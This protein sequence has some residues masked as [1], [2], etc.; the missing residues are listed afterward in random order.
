[1]GKRLLLLS[2]SANYQKEFLAHARDE[3]KRLFGNQVKHVLFLLT[4]F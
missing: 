1:M 2:N 4:I 3:I